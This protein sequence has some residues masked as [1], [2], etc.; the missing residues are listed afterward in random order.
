MGPSIT[1]ANAKFTI[2][3]PGVYSSGVLLAQYSTDEMF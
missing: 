2:V 1:S 3:I